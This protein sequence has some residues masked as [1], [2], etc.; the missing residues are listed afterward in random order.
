M[1]PTALGTAAIACGFYC[2]L[3]HVLLKDITTDINNPPTFT[4]VEVGDLP[5]KSRELIPKA[6]PDLKPVA[7]PDK[8]YLV[9]FASV[10]AVAASVP[11][12]EVT[13]VENGRGV[14]EVV[15]TSPLGFQDDVAIRVQKVS[16]GGVVVDMRSRSRIGVGDLGINAARIRGF[17]KALNTVLGDQGI[18]RLG[19][20]GSKPVNEFGREWPPQKVE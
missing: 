16:T 19:H 17:L 14:V 10:A 2:L 12:W 9:V 3:A 15:A 18:Q 11:R 13:V 5:V 7:Y 20:S 6:Y 8:S 4:S 1:A